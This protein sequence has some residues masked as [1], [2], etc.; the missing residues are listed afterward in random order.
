MDS[1]ISIVPYNSLLYSTIRRSRSIVSQVG[2]WIPASICHFSHAS[3]FRNTS[4]HSGCMLE[5]FLT[6]HNPSS[7]PWMGQWSNLLVPY[8]CDFVSLV[9][10]SLSKLCSTCHIFPLQAFRS[11]LEKIFSTSTGASFQLERQVLVSPHLSKYLVSTHKFHMKFPTLVLTGR[12]EDEK[13]KA[14]KEKNA[15]SSSDR[16]L[17]RIIREEQRRNGTTSRQLDTTS[18]EL[19]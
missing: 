18:H 19:R 14:T 1:Q 17:K 12:L 5:N 6:A 3:I 16:R 8:A 15:T 2:C 7:G 11:L 4:N 9:T 13:D 10:R